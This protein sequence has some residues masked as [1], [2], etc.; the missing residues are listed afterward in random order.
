MIILSVVNIKNSLELDYTACSDVDACN[1]GLSIRKGIK[2][3]YLLRSDV[4][5]CLYP[6][7]KQESEDY[8]T[9][10][11]PG[12]LITDTEYQSDYSQYDCSEN[13]LS[14]NKN[15]IPQNFGIN[16]I[17][18]NPFN[19]ITII[20][21]VLAQ[22]VDVQI[23]IYNINGRLITT[24]INEFQIAGYH[25]ITWDASSYS[26]GIYF[27]NMFSEAITETKKMVLIK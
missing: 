22:N 12:C 23:S 4:S 26:S 25:N 3:E 27:L 13:L 16:Q 17:Y 9:Q 1:T 18:P 7:N 5:S 19:P 6:C 24:L 14:L 8:Y 10:F 21:Y 15:I 20:D 11:H 2:E